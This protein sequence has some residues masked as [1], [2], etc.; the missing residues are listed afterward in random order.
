MDAS[1]ETQKAKPPGSRPH[2]MLTRAESLP[3]LPLESPKP[4][5]HPATRSKLVPP[6]T[7][8]SSTKLRRG[9]RPTASATAHWPSA[10]GHTHRHRDLAH[11]GGGP[12]SRRL[13]TAPQRRDAQ[14]NDV[15]PADPNADQA[16]SQ[17]KP[18]RRGDPAS[19]SLQRDPSVKTHKE[20]T[21]DPQIAREECPTD[22]TSNPARARRHAKSHGAH[23][24]TERN[25]K[26]R[27]LQ[28]NLPTNPYRRD[29][30]NP[31]K[32]CKQCETAPGSP[33]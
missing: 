21:E 12:A 18:A 29:E 14:G 8:D 31:A 11:L 19:R 32:H 3:R 6:R 13:R 4:N 9:E 5:T 2:P 16:P 15:A 24:R 7:A 23:Q 30:S 25:A 33:P 22:T 20:Y 17:P 28:A 26:R 27:S 1:V 10:H